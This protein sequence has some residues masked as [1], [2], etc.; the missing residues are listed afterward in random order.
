MAPDQIYCTVSESDFSLSFQLSSVAPLNILKP[1][2]SLSSSTNMLEFQH[3]NLMF[4]HP[5]CDHLQTVPL[6]MYTVAASVCQAR[7]VYSYLTWHD[8]CCRC[9]QLSRCLQEKSSKLS[10]NTDTDGD[11]VFLLLVEL[12]IKSVEAYIRKTITVASRQI[13]NAANVRCVA[14]WTE[15]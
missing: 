1:W 3:Q 12:K 8:F 14:V 4:Q 10:R 15:D 13:I 2:G 9:Y 7:C 11:C 6:F 5:P